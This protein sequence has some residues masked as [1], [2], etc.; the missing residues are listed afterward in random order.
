MFQIAR[1]QMSVISNLKSVICFM[2]ALLTVEASERAQFWK[3][4]AALG[5]AKLRLTGIDSVALPRESSATLL[6]AVDDLVELWPVALSHS[7]E[8]LPAKNCIVLE[9]SDADWLVENLGSFSIRRE[10][11]RVMVRAAT[12]AGLAN[13]VMALCQDVLGAR[14]YWASDLG[15]EQHGSVPTYFPD[16][17]WREAPDFVQ[18]Q[19]Y[20][21][22]ADFG[23]RNRLN[24][25]Y[26]FN[27]ALAKVFTAELYDQEPELFALVKGTRRRPRGHGGT[28]PQPDFT[29]PRVVELAAEAAMAHF[30][31]HPQSPSFSLSINDNVLFD[32]SEWTELTVE[33]VQYFRNRPNYTDLVFGFMNQ[34]AT[35]LDAYDAERGIASR[36]E[37]WHAR[38]NVGSALEAG[39]S[40]SISSGQASRAP[41]V[42]N[43]SGRSIWT[44]PSG[45]PRYLTALAYYWTEPSPSIPLHPHIMPVLTSDRAQWHD[46]A[47][48]DE[49][50]A[51]AERWMGSGIERM[52]TW[53]YYFGAP[54][55]YPRQF[56]QWIDESLKHLNDI[57]VDVFF[58]QLPSAWGMDGPKAWLAAELLWD[59]QQDAEALLNEYY[60]HFFGAAAGPMRAFY[61]MAEGH[62]N[63]HEGEAEWIKL[64]K[65]EAGIELFTPELIRDMR[66]QIQEAEQLVAG[67]ARRLARVQVVAD[68]FRFT[69]LYAE[70]HRARVELVESVLRRDLSTGQLEDFIN[71]RQLYRDYA[72][73]LIADPM[74]ARLKSF[75]RMM[76]TDPVPAALA[77]GSN[78]AIEGYERIQTALDEWDLGSA[79]SLLPNF[80]LNH[81][82]QTRHSFLGPYVPVVPGWKFDF[83]PSE[84]FKL[85]AIESDRGV[86]IEGADMSSMFTDVEVDAGAAY[87]L[88]LECGYS[89]SPDNRTQVQLTWKDEAG[90]QLK[91]QLPLRFPNGQSDGVKSVTIPM[92][93]PAGAAELRIHFTQSRQYA[94]DFFELHSVDLKR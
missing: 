6:A 17:P 39:A 48:R 74:H 1:A 38:T 64:Y 33:P 86:R 53:D 52:A 49:D 21:S 60:T 80:N 26:S 90:K 54:Y 85:L 5:S 14:W 69:E 65:D 31:A 37:P 89:I 62:R 92:V 47:Y 88:Q 24:R 46:P 56:S 20:P 59:S 83:R 51:L 11:T 73:E 16:R 75:T 41:T 36:G 8:E 43:A 94:G 23:R 34:V 72:Q 71:A 68:A 15:F 82:G 87:F 32:T 81:S 18:R 35:R 45:Q 30:E 13:A 27:H 2:T 28:D 4:E 55:P 84:K 29:H 9:H 50:R 3:P 93:A 22:D 77:A 40:P 78:P 67:D 91:V 76:Q 79:V 70:M 66:A 58:S 44:T 7:D 61:E 63:E 25:V 12:D 10:R 57:G 42:V 19:L